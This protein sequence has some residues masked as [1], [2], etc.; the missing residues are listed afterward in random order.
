MVTSVEEVKAIL[1]RQYNI[2]GTY[3]IDPETLVVDVEGS[4]ALR[5]MTPHFG[6]QFGKVSES[7]WCRERQLTSLKGAP[8]TVG[9]D[10]DCSANKLT[11]LAHGPTHAGTYNCNYQQL[12]SLEGAPT[13]VT[14]VFLCRN[15]LIT[16]LNHLPSGITFLDCQDNPLVN[17]EHVPLDLENISCSW[18]RDL[19]LLRLLTCKSVSLGWE[20]PLAV[21][22]IITKYE[23]QG[24]PGALKAAAELIKAGYKE[25]ARW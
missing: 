4:V 22:Q 23:G 12:T 1:F 10:F 19:P 6:V 18:R 20:C 11:S 16:S 13:T 9:K 25:N 21:D 2:S 5:A 7:F 3:T 14:G 8:H 15:N 24:K 17:F